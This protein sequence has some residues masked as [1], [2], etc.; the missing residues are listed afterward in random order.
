MSPPKLHIEILTSNTMV[1]G[2]EGFRRCLVHEGGAFMNSNHILLRDPTELPP[3]VRIHKK[4]AAGKR[5]L[6]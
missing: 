4:S 5:A 6:M 3:M 2:D 1:Q